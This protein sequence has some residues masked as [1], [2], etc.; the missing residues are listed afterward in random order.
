[1]ESRAWRCWLIAGALVAAA[2]LVRL[3][4]VPLLREQLPYMFFILATLLTARYCGAGPGAAALLVGGFIANYLFVTPA[5][6]Q[7]LPSGDQLIGMAAYL[8]IGSLAIW[9][10]ESLHRARR[11]ADMLATHS[12]ANSEN[13]RREI[14]GRAEIEHRLRDSERRYR[15]LADSIP[16]IVW[17]A[18]P[19]GV[20]NYN[21]QWMFDYFGVSPEQMQAK[22][23]TPFRHPD[24][25]AEATQRW[26]QAI[27]SGEPYECMYR[28]LRGSDQSWRWHLARAVPMHDESGKVLLWFGTCTDIDDRVRAEDALRA[29]EQEFRA[30]FELAGSGKALADP[31]SG[32][33]VRVNRKLCE[34]TGYSS[35]ELLKM[36][37]M[38]LTHPADRTATREGS[39]RMSRG[40]SSVYSAE[41]RYVRKDGQTIWVQVTA[42]MIYDAQGK[43]L[44]AAGLIEDV[45]ERRRANEALRASEERFRLAAAAV[46]GMV[47]DW[48]VRGGRVFRSDGLSAL[49]GISADEAPQTR[50]WWRRASIRTTGH[51]SV[52][53]ST[54][55]GSTMARII[56]RPNIAFSTPTDRGWTCGTV[57]T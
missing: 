46:N 54:Q 18:R 30:V 25:R 34:M 56:M 11:R 1:M 35:D 6:G 33:F 49:V 53:S 21:N 41:K 7:R 32:R 12:D 37:Y 24:D 20:T 26:T 57:A 8:M 48:D 39:D 22:G 28:L 14:A 42:T 4:L 23:W 10:C 52:A 47:Y 9:I 31:E 45:T 55:F 36:S 3:S 16:Q 13:L 27:R 38:D 51:A 19:D 50:E 29:S 17:T 44:H 15:F 2:S 43:P 40:E 5:F